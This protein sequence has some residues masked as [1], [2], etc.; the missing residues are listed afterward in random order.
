MI[1]T[2]KGSRFAGAGFG[3]ALRQVGRAA[4][5]GFDFGEQK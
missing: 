3:H 1:V 5:G 4:A 2:P